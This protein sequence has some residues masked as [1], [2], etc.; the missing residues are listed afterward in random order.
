MGSED[1]TPIIFDE[2]RVRFETIPIKFAA[3][4]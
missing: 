4:E 2:D 3:E 1:T